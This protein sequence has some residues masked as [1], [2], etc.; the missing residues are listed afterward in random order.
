MALFFTLNIL[1]SMFLKLSKDIL[2]KCTVVFV[3]GMKAYGGVEIEIHSFLSS[4][5]DGRERL[6]SIPSRITSVPIEEKAV[7]A[8]ELV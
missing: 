5:L 1:Q 6:A 4:T 2:V 7:R 8:P 3:Y